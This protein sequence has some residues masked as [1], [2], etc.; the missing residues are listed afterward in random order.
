MR[1]QSVHVRIGAFSSRTAEL[2]SSLKSFLFG[3]FREKQYVETDGAFLNLAY[4]F[5]VPIFAAWLVYFILP[6]FLAAASFKKMRTSED[7]NA[8]MTFMLAILIASSLL[9]HFWIQYLPEKFP[10]CL[11][12]GFVLSYILVNALQMRHE[13]ESLHNIAAG[14][15]SVLSSGAVR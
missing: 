5:G 3:A 13:D 1:L 8:A 15:E 11:F 4:N 12:I 9:T 7:S 6:V 2:F 14:N 10:A